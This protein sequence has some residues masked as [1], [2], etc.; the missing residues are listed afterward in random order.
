MGKPYKY[1]SVSTDF[2]VFLN[3]FLI[4]STVIVF[5]VLVFISYQNVNNEFISNSMSDSGSVCADAVRDYL[6]VSQQYEDEEVR[7]SLLNT[8][9]SSNVI[10]DKG[11]IY[12][13]DGEGGVL[14]SN[15]HSLIA[16]D[17]INGEI[18]LAISGVNNSNGKI[19]QSYTEITGTT[20]RLVSADAIGDTGLYAIVVSEIQSSA[21][22]SEYMNI[23]FYPV[24]VSLVA[25]IAL[26][27]GFVGLTIRPL[28]DISRTMSSV[29]AG[30]LTARVDEK[31]TMI[32]DRSGMLTLS[33]DLTEMARNVN[34]M[35]ES[36]ENQE[37][38]RS[39]FISSVAHDIR[40]PLTSINGFVTAMLDGTIPP[41]LYEKYLTRI[42]S[43]VD[44]IRSLVVSMTEASSLSN[45]SPDLMD[46]FDLKEACDEMI[47]DLEPQLRSKNIT[48]EQKID[49]TGGTL[50]YG[51][52]QLLCRVLFNIVTNAIK[53]TP[54]GGK[55]IVSSYQ[56]SK[57]NAR[58]ISVEDSGPGVE[59]EKRNRV[60]ESFYKVDSS[61]KQ[62]GFGLGLYICKQ[63][64]TG[65]EQT[66]RLDESPELG[67]AMFV[68]TF[69]LPPKK[70]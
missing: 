16:T 46:T 70:D 54:D 42:K 9:L 15:S 25:A 40:T 52:I 19:Y 13:T 3:T 33:S 68:F 17:D 48:I 28:R 38:D 27:I 43:E 18:R 1:K 29:A 12:I 10:N 67:G 60:F 7:N 69:P 61:R 8:L 41:E 44:R 64:L 63:I 62:E 35:I 55:I 51:E 23:I 26:F 34:S 56:D 37:N 21:Y 59:P 2:A 53:F 36:L 39:M 45:V 65:H 49:E 66:I 58:V 14:F 11:S 22:V 5:A 32:G 31:Y 6:M 57:A 4:I 30:D 24:L 50:V 47:A 20:S